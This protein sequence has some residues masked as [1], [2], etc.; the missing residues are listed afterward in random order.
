MKSKV[1]AFFVFLF[2][3]LNSTFLFSQANPLSRKI[4][5]H[6]KNQTVEKSLNSIADAANV[7]FSY[8]ADILPLDSLVSLNFEN[9]EIQKILNYMFSARFDYKTSGNYIIIQK[10]KIAKTETKT[11]KT[12]EI[13][14]SG[15]VVDK[16]SGAKIAN[17]SIYNINGKEQIL[18][19]TNGNFS[20][21]FKPG[22][23]NISLAVN[24]Q[25]YQDTVLMLQSDSNETL[26]IFLNPKKNEFINAAVNQGD[27]IVK[28][29]IEQIKLVSRLVKNELMTH[30]LNI[31]YFTERPFQVSLLPFLGTNT[32]LSGSIVNNFSLNIFS[33]YSYGVK[34]V[35]LG[36]ILNI[37]RGFVHGLQLSGFGNFTGKELV[38]IQ[39][40]GFLNQNLAKVKGAQLAGFYNMCGDSMEGAQLAGFINISRRV[41]TGLQAAGFIN[42]SGR[43]FNGTQLAGFMNIGSSEFRGIQLAGFMNQAHSMKG[44]QIAGFSNFVS[45][46][47]SGIQMAGF[48]NVSTSTIKGVQFSCFMNIAKKVEGMQIGIINI[49]DSVSG[50]SLGILNFVRKGYHQIVLKSDETAY[51][52]LQLKIGTAALYTIFGFSVLPDTGAKA[53]SAEFGFGTHLFAKRRL[54]INFDL[55]GV[56]YF[57]SD[58]LFSHTAQNL[59]LSAEIN[60][61][62]F[63]KCRIFAGPNYNLNV[64]DASGG[65][66]PPLPAKYFSAYHLHQTAGNFVFR[67]WMGM[68]MGLKFNF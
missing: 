61:K 30:A 36:G 63:G 15:K 49:A 58:L 54:G 19:D 43:N 52:G 8:N 31:G 11:T 42:F 53:A 45:G 2:C 56:N 26:E 46:G 57:T 20:I 7:H 14:V 27:S 35:E 51:T 65:S 29:S 13:K 66:I 55:T 68:N 5:L 23:D 21:T 9:T 62:L 67:G 10:K 39:A 12:N 48:M 37:N 32:G 22:E 18:T 40:A 47:F 1:L 44:I 28:Q 38:G 24:N 17:T 60:L 33:G 25:N 50:V 3:L 34:G 4:N 64:Y 16:G 41:S 6:L 59:K